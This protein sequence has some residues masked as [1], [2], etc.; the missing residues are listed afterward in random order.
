METAP[1]GAIYNIGGGSE[2]SLKEIIE[3]CERLAGSTLDVRYGAAAAGD[4]R[5]TASD[6]SLIHRDTGWVPQVSLEEGLSTHL[7]WAA[8]LPAAPALAA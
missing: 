2:T 7:A 4:V 3:M 8:A 5:R 1:A 6:T